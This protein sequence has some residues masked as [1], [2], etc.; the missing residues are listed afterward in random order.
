[1]KKILLASIVLFTAFINSCK[2]PD[3]NTNPGV[4]ST[5]SSIDTIF[6]MLQVPSKFVTFNASVGS[7]FYGNSGTRYIFPAG[8]FQDAYGNIVNGIVQL[9][10]KE[11]LKKG[12]MIFTKALP[13]CNDIP[14]VSG[15]EVYTNATQSGQQLYLVPG[16]TFQANIPQGKTP[17]SGL[18]Y[19]ISTVVND[20]VSKVAWN[21][22]DSSAAGV[23]YNGDTISI[24]SDSLQWINADRFE[25]TTSGSTFNVTI[26]V[27]GGT[28][29]SAKGLSTYALYDTCRGV[30]PLNDYVGS[31][32]AST[33]VYTEN[34]LPGM[35]IY[36][37]SFGL[38]NNRFY[39]GV[40]S[41]V[42]PVDK[43]NYTILLK[44]VDP[45]A[46]K[47]QLNNLNE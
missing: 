22:K 4:Y 29:S 46:F 30:W 26:S 5:Y 32:N 6:T 35:P 24:L 43:G 9:E 37:V 28:I 21:Q 10:V 1:M 20:P 44:E 33:G 14:L 18:S 13:V 42:K 34:Y 31:Y 36:L 47:G 7:S 27:A 39:G 16:A 3:S 8:C 2:K 15:G 45:I 41:L 11:L 38:I 19:F 40:S 17:V 25:A 23:V 12:D